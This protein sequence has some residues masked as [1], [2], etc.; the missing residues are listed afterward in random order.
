MTRA[1]YLAPH[2]RWGERMGDGEMVDVLLRDGL[3][4]VFNDYHMGETAENL[5]DMYSI[6]RAEQ[7]RYAAQSI[8]S[9][10]VRSC[11]ARITSRRHATPAVPYPPDVHD[12]SR[13]DEIARQKRR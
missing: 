2:H 7:D 12:H 13:T 4:D 8:L 11:T 10:P 1:P 3:W 9:Q 5:A 6:S